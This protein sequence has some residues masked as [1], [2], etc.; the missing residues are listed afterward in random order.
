MSKICPKCGVTLDDNAMF[1]TNCGEPLA[2]K[3]E[4]AVEAAAEKVEE[5][6]EET[7]EKVEEA[8]EAAAEKVEEAAQEP[9]AP[10]PVAPVPVAT[11]AAPK[12]V[13]EP[14]TDKVAGVGAFFWLNLLFSIPFIGL[15]CCIIFC[16]APKNKNIKNFSKANLIW[17]LLGL[18]I[19]LIGV[20]VFAILFSFYGDN[21]VSFLSG[22]GLGFLFGK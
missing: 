21:I 11:P 15:I 3:A 16:F 2:E 18:I 17:T 10:T 14:E 22:M 4:E 20:G 19:L 9:V 7:A 5:T 12:A 13:K 6:V 1:C 8:T